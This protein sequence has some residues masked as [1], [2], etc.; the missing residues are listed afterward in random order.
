M[1]VSTVPLLVVL[2]RLERNW[3]D[4]SM[5]KSPCS[6]S[7]KSCVQIPNTHVKSQLSS[8]TALALVL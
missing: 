7:V 5:G 2:R 8:H 1:G 4:G 6:A 3:E